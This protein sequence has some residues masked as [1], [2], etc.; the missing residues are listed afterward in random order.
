MNFLEMTLYVNE[1][2]NLESLEMLFMLGWSFWHRRNKWIHES[3]L[4][5]P[6]VSIAHALSLRKGFKDTLSISNNQL[7]KYGHW[8]RPVEG[9]MKLNV[10]G[11][12]IFDQNK[13]CIGLILRNTYGKTRLAASLPKEGIKTP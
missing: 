5:E 7:R 2:T 11:V 9:Y 13:V 8:N 3:K 4:W 6:Q 12:V 1:K 10:D